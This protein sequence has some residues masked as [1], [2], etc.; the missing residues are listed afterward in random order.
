VA[1]GGALDN[2]G[3]KTVLIKGS[4]EERAKSLN[5]FKIVQ[6]LSAKKNIYHDFHE[7]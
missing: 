4:L 1:S 7:C 2:N 3:K 6:K 5:P